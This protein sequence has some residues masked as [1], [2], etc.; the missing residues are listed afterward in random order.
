MSHNHHAWHN[1]IILMQ[2]RG[3]EDQEKV[4]R[5]AKWAENEAEVAVDNI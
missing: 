4:V 2:D 1:P 5:V 3:H